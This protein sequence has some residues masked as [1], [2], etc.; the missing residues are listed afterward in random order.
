MGD[1]KPQQPQGSMEQKQKVKPEERIAARL[2]ESMGKFSSTAVAQVLAEE[3]QSLRTEQDNKLQTYNSTLGS[4]ITMG[5]LTST[6][7]L[8]VVKGSPEQVKALRN[9]RT[10]A[11]AEKAQD[12]SSTDS[13]PQIEELVSVSGKEAL[14]YLQDVAEA[15]LEVA[16]ETSGG[17]AKLREELDQKAAG[18][19]TT[20]ISAVMAA[21]SGEVPQ[22]VEKDD[23]ALEVVR[24]KKEPKEFLQ[25]IV[26]SLNNAVSMVVSLS[27][28]VAS[29]ASGN[30]RQE[31]ES[32][33][34]QLENGLSDALVKVLGTTLE[35][36]TEER[37]VEERLVSVGS[38]L[39]LLCENFEVLLPD[40]SGKKPKETIQV[41]E[42][43]LASVQEHIRESEK[44]GDQ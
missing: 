24:V 23:G 2:A 20:D 30:E 7:S 32:R 40:C 37:T 14:T 27:S 44:Q 18:T 36:S 28:K 10:K 41:Y 6:V 35:Q 1:N 16:L 33:V 8:N 26:D 42:K 43:A 5:D 4:K 15:G 34:E 9:E 11:Q 29:L 39:V 31:L 3:L 12:E 19:Q 38:Y 21:L 17:L 22:L 25:A 13:G